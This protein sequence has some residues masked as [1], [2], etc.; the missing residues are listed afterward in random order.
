MNTS[1]RHGMSEQ[2]EPRV[3][4]VGEASS[5][6]ARAFWQAFAGIALELLDDRELLGEDHAREETIA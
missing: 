6:A 1:L 4:V 5:D 2:T 3:E